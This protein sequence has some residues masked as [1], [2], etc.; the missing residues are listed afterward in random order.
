MFLNYRQGKQKCSLKYTVVNYMTEK[1]LSLKVTL[2]IDLTIS[3]VGVLVFFS[4]M[5]MNLFIQNF[6]TMVIIFIEVV[7]GVAL[8]GRMVPNSML[9][10]IATIEKV[11]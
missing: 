6:T 2:T 5:K 10:D 4:L 7:M 3:L 9:L 1:V 11:I 8:K